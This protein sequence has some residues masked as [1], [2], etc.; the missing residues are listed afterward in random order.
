SNNNFIPDCDLSNFL[1]NGECGQISNLNFGKFLPQATQFDDS[2]IK[3]NRDFLWDINVEV[4]HELLHGLSVT[5]AYNHNWDGN[6]I[7]T[8]TLVNG[9]L[10][11]P[12][13]FDEFCVTVPND[14]RVPNA[15]QKQ[16]GYYDVKPQ[17]FGQGVLKVTNAAQFGKQQRYWDG[18]T[19]AAN[20]RLP[21][22]VQLGGGVDLGRQVDDHCYTVSIPNQPYDINNIP[23]NGGASGVGGL[24]PFCR[25][26]TGWADNLDARFRGSFPLRAGLNAS[27]IYR[28]TPGAVENGLLTVTSSQVAFVNPTRTALNAATTVVLFTPNSIFG[29]RFNQLDLA[30]N[31][32][33]NLGLARCRA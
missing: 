29:P 3:H 9:A 27:F 24:N 32:T 5:A 1:L 31:K 6:F 22:G 4:D 16:C 26:I 7:V 14:P 8:E 18:F 15:G 23:L 12:E 20:G 33:W 17:L 21:R 11:G 2:V 30:L 10:L 13:S 19:F 25:I 28:N